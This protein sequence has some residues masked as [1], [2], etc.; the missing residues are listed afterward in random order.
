MS[1]FDFVNYFW[2]TKNEIVTQR[3]NRVSHQVEQMIRVYY[4]N[5]SYNY[6][7]CR[8]ALFHS[9]IL[10]LWERTWIVWLSKRFWCW[11][12]QLDFWKQTVIFI[13][14]NWSHHIWYW[15]RRYGTM[16]VFCQLYWAKVLL[17]ENYYLIIEMMSWTFM[18]SVI[19]VIFFLSM[20]ASQ[21]PKSPNL[22][23]WS[24][25]CSRCSCFLCRPPEI[26]LCCN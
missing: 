12:I 22:I 20:S 6:Y 10:W 7:Y 24:L 5:N 4:F 16:F 3:N 18:H 11:S 26:F 15:W 17:E 9:W 1:H 23:G 8:K 19:P 25:T 14:E 2:S 13:S 21:N